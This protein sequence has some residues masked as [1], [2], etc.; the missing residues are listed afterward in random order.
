[1]KITQE[2]QIK[3]LVKDFQYG[4]R[5][6]FRRIYLYYYNKLLR[7]G[8]VITR[9][10]EVVEDV[11][12]DVFMWL[13]EN[14]GKVKAIRNFDE[15][16]FR[17][18]KQNLYKK[19]NYKLSSEKHNHKATA[20]KGE[21]YEQHCEIKI[22]EEETSRE[23][24]KTLPQHQQEVLYLRYYEG[25][26]FIEIGSIMGTNDQVTRNYAYRALKSLRKSADINKV[27]PD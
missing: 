13:V 17:A 5:R 11:I 6:A 19:F 3:V 14:P 1:M 21:V 27:F 18:V 26:S 16:L 9:D 12:H 25:L 10:K 23:L 20:E 8:L 15:Y 22:I 7:Y 24:I 4:N 2:H